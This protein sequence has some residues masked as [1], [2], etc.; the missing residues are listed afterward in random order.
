MTLFQL[1]RTEEVPEN[2]LKQFI[3]KGKE[4]LVINQNMKFYCLDARCTHAGAP[5]AE[6][7]LENGVLK[8]P[9]H[10]SKFK[11]ETGEVVRGPAKKQLRIYHSMVEDN[12][13]FIE[14]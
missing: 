12:N 11:I 13:L 7:E 5:L 2:E 4:I 8:C 1:C 6:G 3:L 9:W 14:L 10:G